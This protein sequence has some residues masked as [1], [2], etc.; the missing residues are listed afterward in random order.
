MGKSL[1][2]AIITISLYNINGYKIKPG[3][4]IDDDYPLHP[5]LEKLRPYL[6]YR[7]SPRLTSSEIKQIHSR[8]L[9][10]YDSINNKEVIMPFDDFFKK[11]KNSSWIKQL[12]SKYPGAIKELG[13]FKEFYIP[14]WQG[15]HSQ[16]LQHF[17]QN[18]LIYNQFTVLLIQDLYTL[19]KSHASG[20]PE[21]NN[22]PSKIEG[23][24]NELKMLTFNLK[25]H[26]IQIKE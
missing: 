21:S 7:E 1:S 13:V 25:K 18:H 17:N 2:I 22:L 6:V 16:A 15:K 26:N 20:Y 10:S 23:I 4:P 9:S 5:S 3:E 11:D 12:E 24:F 19:L 8:Q 14:L